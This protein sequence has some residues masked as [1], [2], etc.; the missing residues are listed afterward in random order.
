MKCCAKGDEWS[1]EAKKCVPKPQCK[2]NHEFDKKQNK[3]VAKKLNC[4]DKNGGKIECPELCYAKDGKIID[5]PKAKL[6]QK[7][8][9]RIT[10]AQLAEKAKKAEKP[11]ADSDPF[12]EKEKTEEKEEKEPKDK[13]G[14]APLEAN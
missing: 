12:K 2:L 1:K 6:T 11:K 9:D 3:C 13:K 14:K 7:T 5:C 10:E 8:Q 4:K